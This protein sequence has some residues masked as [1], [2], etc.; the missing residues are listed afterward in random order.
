MGWEEFKKLFAFLV[1]FV[2]VHGNS[3]KTVSLEEQLF[4]TLI[5]FR[6]NPAFEF[7]ADIFNIG[8]TTAWD[9]FW[10]WA[11][12]LYIKISFLVKYPDRENIYRIIPP[13]FKKRYPRLT[14]IIDCFEIFMESPKNLKARSKTYSNYKKHCT[15]K[16][17][18]CCN[19]LGAITFLSK[20]YGGR[21]SDITIV[22]ESGFISP[23]YHFPGDQILADRGFTLV[24]EF[25]VQCGAELIMPSFTKGQDQLPA[26]HVESSRK[27]SNIR[28]H[29]ERVI[30]LIKNRF[31]ILQGTLTHQLVKSIKDESEDAAIATIDKLVHVCAS[32]VN[33]GESIV[34]KESED[35]ES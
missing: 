21:A 35:S 12:L 31:S 1:E 14:G 24:E 26:S 22:K 29:I 3:L 7:L 18:I 25:A 13:V 2:N 15:V 10:K 11:D 17:L 27:V 33:L 6:Q 28:I 20:A 19:P 9:I 5:K 34:F 30:G 4:L 23:L 16:F 32:L 8:K